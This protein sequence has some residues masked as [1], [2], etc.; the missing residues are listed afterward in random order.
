MQIRLVSIAL[1]VWCLLASAHARVSPDYATQAEALDG[2]GGPATSSSYGNTGSIGMIAGISS[3]SAYGVEAG[4]LPQSGNPA[5]PEIA[6][7]DGTDT[8][9]ANERQSHSGTFHFPHAPVGTGTLQTFTIR[10]TGSLDL[11]LTTPVPSGGNAGDFAVN[12]TGMLL[13]VPPSGQTTFNVVFTPGGG[14]DRSTTL[15]IGNNDTDEGSFTID[16]DNDGLNDVAEFNYAPLGFDPFV[17]QDAMVATLYGGANAASLYT[18]G[19]VQ[20]LN[21]STPLLTRDSGTGIFKLTLELKRSSNLANGS[22]QPFP[23]TT[24]GTSIN[25]SGHIEFQF[26]SPD[27]AEFY[28]IEAK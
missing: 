13:T 25:A 17:A 3:S 21:V 18:P 11:T 1:F 6:V 9:P 23:F 22:F 15:T 4:F 20:A 10:N 12:T 26:T 14:K 28:R 7:F 5:G 24:L 2:G 27:N 19:Q 8:S 16:T